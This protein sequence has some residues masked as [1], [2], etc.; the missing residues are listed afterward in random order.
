MDLIP[1]ELRGLHISSMTL[2]VIPL[3]KRVNEVE[4]YVPHIFKPL[5]T[6]L[7]LVQL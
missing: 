4:L 3:K 1:V 7:K 5:Y 6:P 2:T